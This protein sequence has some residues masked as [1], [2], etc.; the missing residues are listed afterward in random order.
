MNL[1]MICL[2]F[3]KLQKDSYYY[4]E[5]IVTKLACFKYGAFCLMLVASQTL[6]YHDSDIMLAL[7]KVF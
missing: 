7:E 2:L 1:S 3:Y 5:L 6:P 4:F